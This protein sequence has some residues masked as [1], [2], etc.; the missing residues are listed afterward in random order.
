MNIEKLLKF[1]EGLINTIGK[2]EERNICI[3]EFADSIHPEKY[4]TKQTILKLIECSDNRNKRVNLE[5]IKD[6]DKIIAY[7]FIE[8]VLGLD[9][10]VLARVLSQ[11]EKYI[12]SK[13][14]I[15]DMLYLNVGVKYQSLI[16][17]I[18][19]E[20][21]NFH[22]RLSDFTNKYTCYIWT[23]E[24]SGSKHLCVYEL[25]HYHKEDCMQF[26]YDD[27]DELVTDLRR[28]DRKLGEWF[29][30]RNKMYKEEKKY[31][32]L[33][34]ELNK[35]PFFA[36][37][38]GIH[39]IQY[40]FYFWSSLYSIWNV[41]YHIYLCQKYHEKQE[42]FINMEQTIRFEDDEYTSD[43]DSIKIEDMIDTIKATNGKP[44][45]CEVI[46]EDL[47]TK[48]EANS[49]VIRDIT[50]ID[51]SNNN[52]NNLYM[53]SERIDSNAFLDIT[54]SYIIKNSDDR[55][56]GRIG[57]VMSVF[58][59]DQNFDINK[60]V[61]ELKNLYYNNI[62]IYEIDYPANITIKNLGQSNKEFVKLI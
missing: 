5:N 49:S 38:E 59:F 54:D 48:S 11:L 24:Y 3:Q 1:R 34:E 15:L 6:E 32:D 20:I 10:N 27:I 17:N 9:I 2:D 18:Y 61:M 56:H 16:F 7:M 51:N 44:Y 41:K 31:N 39:D 13:K 47:P 21:N 62:S 4:I 12:Y 37:K 46:I 19:D 26:N 52:R 55:G 45:E 28:L 43:L 33:A 14:E 25:G 23:H 36:E 22:N 29:E 42:Y 58:Y 8:H 50:D 30:F 57:I 40:K 60:F 35:D 53:L